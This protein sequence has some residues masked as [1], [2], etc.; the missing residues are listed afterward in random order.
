VDLAT[1][2]FHLSFQHLANLFGTANDTSVARVVSEFQ[3]RILT[4]DEPNKATRF[5]TQILRDLNLSLDEIAAAER[6]FEKIDAEKLARRGR[7]ML[8]FVATSPVRGFESEWASTG[9]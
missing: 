7:A 3:K 8:R 9:S 2:P 1:I 6:D 5:D 4:S